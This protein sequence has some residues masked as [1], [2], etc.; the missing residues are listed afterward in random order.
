MW[1]NRWRDSKKCCA[2]AAPRFAFLSNFVL[3]YLFLS[4]SMRICTNFSM[5]PFFAC[6]FCC[7]LSSSRSPSTSHSWSMLCC[8]NVYSFQRYTT[9][10]LALLLE[11]SR[12]HLFKHISQNTEQMYKHH[13][14]S[15]INIKRKGKLQKKKYEAH[16]HRA[17]VR[18]RKRRGTNGDGCAIVDHRVTRHL[19]TCD[20][21]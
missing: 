6:F 5:T 20:V 17:R 14:T 11:S 3:V 8:P 10:A 9:V 1:N 4:R 21:N 16:I 15:F 2:S 18:E 12:A 7:F 13:Q 19:V